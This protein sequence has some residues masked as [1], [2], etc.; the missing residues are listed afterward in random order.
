MSTATD[1]AAV[2]VSFTADEAAAVQAA[3]ANFRAQC[4]KNASDPHAHIREAAEDDA[5][6][7]EAAARRVGD[8]IAEAQCTAGLDLAETLA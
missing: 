2:T 8:A 1:P 4:R 6:N 7:A 5:R 3:L